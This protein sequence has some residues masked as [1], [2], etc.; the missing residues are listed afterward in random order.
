MAAATA[1][2]AVLPGDGT[3]PEV[4]REGFKV[5]EAVSKKSASSTNSRTTTSAASATSRPARS[6]R[7]RPSKELQQFDAIYLGAVGHPDVKPGILEK[8]LLLRLRFE[9]DQYI[10]LRPV[11]LY[12][13]VETPLKDK[14]PEDID[15]VVVRENTEGL[16]SGSRRLPVQGHAA[17][18]LHPGQGHH[19]LR[20][21]AGDPLR[22]RPVPPPQQ[23]EE[24]PHPG[25]QDQR[26]DL[27]RRHLVAGVQRDRRQGLPRHQ[28]RLQ[29]RRRLLHVV[30]QEPRVLRRDRHRQHVRRHHHRPRRDDPGRPG[31]GRRRQHQPQGRL[32]CSSRWAA[33]PR[34]TPARTSST[35]S[36]P[37][38]RWA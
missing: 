36:P 32:A 33:A 18:S 28:A 13:G 27:R 17:G 37:S 3:G 30:R 9:L 8:G 14:G 15:F 34:S 22:L 4:V 25:P 21:R 2:I 38:P 20:R 6:C 1:K 23:Q 19:P 35:R 29:P 31:R 11:Q 16:Y 12:P 10:N 5:M 7:T 26:A 24:D